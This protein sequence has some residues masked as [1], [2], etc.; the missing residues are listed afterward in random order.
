[1]VRPSVE[2]PWSAPVNLGS[3]INTKDYEDFARL[4]PDGHTLYFD[5]RDVSAPDDPSWYNSADIW[6]SS[7]LPF[8]AVGLSGAGGGYSQ[9]FDVLGAESDAAGTPLPS[10][11][12]F[13]ANDIIFSNATTDKFPASRRN[14]AGVYNGGVNGDSDRALVTDVSLEEGGELDFRA[15]VADAPVQALRLGFDLEAWQLLVGA[16]QAEAAFHVVLEADTG[17]G[18]SQVADLGL[19]TTGPTLTRPST[20]SLVDGNDPMYRV[21]YDSGPLDLDVPSRMRRYGCVGSR[22]TPL[23]EPSSSAWTTSRSALPP[24]AMPTSTACSTRATYRGAGQ[25][26]V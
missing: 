11:W 2:A 4:A 13:T 10:G 12:T 26:R 14:Y 20:G 19:V 21:N 8:E 24:R 18:F 17:D 22:P 15:V 25:R 9:D 23:G 16:D 1:M 3:A 7:V 6:Q 5:R